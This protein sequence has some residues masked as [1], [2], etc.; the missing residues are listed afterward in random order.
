MRVLTLA[1]FGVLMASGAFLASTCTNKRANSLKGRSISAVLT[2][3]E[4]G[5][6]NGSKSYITQTHILKYR[7]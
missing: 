3:G 1:K 6:L 2:T 5:S 4:K 7:C